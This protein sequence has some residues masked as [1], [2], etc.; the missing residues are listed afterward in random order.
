M[1]FPEVC[2]QQAAAHRHGRLSITQSCEI[3]ALSTPRSLKK[4]SRLGLGWDSQALNRAQL[5]YHQDKTQNS[6]SYRDMM[7]KLNTLHINSGPPGPRLRY[8]NEALTGTF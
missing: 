5:P 3:A 7:T 1:D 2:L 6:A 4:G 8:S